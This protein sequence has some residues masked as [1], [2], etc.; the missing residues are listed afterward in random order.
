MNKLSTKKMLTVLISLA[1]VFS[2][3]AVISMAAQ[4]AY[5]TSSPN[6][7]SDPAFFVPGVTTVSYISSGVTFPV[8]SVIYFYISTSTSATGIIGSYVGS[9]SLT[10]GSPTLANVVNISIPSSVSPGSYYL[11][12][13]DS[14]SSTAAGATFPA[15]ASITVSSISPEIALSTSSQV[16]GGTIYISSVASHPFDPASTIEVFLNYP[17]SSIVLI[18]TVTTTSAGLIPSLTSFTVPTNEPQ[19]TYTVVAQE[20]SSLSTAFPNGAPDGI[21]ADASFTLYPSITVSVPDISG[22]T[23]SAFTITGYGFTAGAAIAPYTTTPTAVTVGGVNAVQAGTTVSSSGSFTL[24]IT[25]LAAS[26]TTTGPQTIVITTSPVTPS[27]SFPNIIYVSRPT[28]IPQI[29]VTDLSTST[30]SGYVGDSL[31]II[32]LNMLASSPITVYMA[33][34]TI[35]SGSTDVNGFFSSISGSVPAVPGGTYGVYAEI[36][37]PGASSVSTVSEY[38][39]TQYTVLPLILF[40]QTT[41]TPI[42]GE[43]TPVGASV[44]VSGTGLAPNAEYAITDTG[45]IS[46]GGTG[47]VVYDSIVLGFSTYTGL[48]TSNTIAPDDMGVISDATGS[49]SISY[50]ITYSSLPTG[51]NETISVSGPAMTAQSTYYYAIGAATVTIGAQSYNPASATQMVSV[52]VSGLIPYG[53][54]I[55]TLSG[56]QPVGTYSIVIGTVSSSSSV[57]DV[58]VNG[59]KTAAPTFYTTTGS[60]SLTFPASALSLGLNTVNAVYSNFAIWTTTTDSIVGSSQVL[61]S[62]PSTTVGSVVPVLTSAS[63]GGMLEYNLY[64][65]PASTTVTYSYY[66]VSG[67][68]SSTVSTDAN[69]AANVTFTSPLSPADNYV[70]TFAITFSG[71]TSTVSSTFTLVG[72]LSS[73]P[74]TNASYPL[75]TTTS[76]LYPGQNVT[77]YAYGLSPET[78]YGIYA[79]TS[80]TVPT[81][82]TALAYFTSDSTGSDNSGVTVTLPSTLVSGGSYYLDVVAPTSIVS[83][84]EPALASFTFMAGTYNNI[85]G[86]TYNYTT[87]TLSAFPTELVNFAWTPATLPNAVGGGSTFGPVE[88]TVLLNGTAYTTFP[89][90]FDPT[91]GLI[92]GSFAAPNNNSGAY[93]TVQLEWT[94]IDY[95]SSTGVSA[96]VNTYTMPSKGAPTLA[97]VSGA[98]AL[99]VAISTSDIA[100]IITSS[101]NSAMKVPLSELNASVTAINGLTANITTAFGKM[102]ATLSSIN[103][104]VASISSGQALVVTKLGTIETSLSSINAS[105]MMVSGNVVTL[106][107]TLGKVQTSLSSIGATVSSTASSVS[108]LVGSAAT[109]L[110]DVGPLSGQITGVSN[111]VATIQTSMGKLNVSV[112]QIQT[113]SNQIKTDSGTL[114]IFLIVVIVL[115][116]ITLVVAFLAVSNTNKLAKKLEE[117]K[118]Q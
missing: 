86:P 96:I 1:M 11:L 56:A 32:V 20:T 101:I 80:A 28:G 16:A 37:T 113:S 85:F 76:A 117:Q 95:A 40:M 21:T 47:N 72:T 98:G 26:I 19:G 42:T 112:A 105:L 99:V 110:T 3:L 100:S 61:G 103:A 17:G 9:T 78:Y 2:A 97:L 77:L 102:T 58:Y 46:A 116:L 49:F 114:E 109:I 25:A 55:A 66:T 71:T 50:L 68:Q 91:T 63:P 33:G 87:N 107:T 39:F 53:S 75:T 70:I 67:K 104:T 36:A 62:T 30:N 48:T 13:S 41:T 88:V 23:S 22:S 81:G 94:Q 10:A 69:G 38:A 29:T 43:Y 8:G 79:E 51:A 4:P 6:M 82:A 84:S 35:V 34:T 93:W 44:T 74:Y 31:S 118:K 73:V 111:G 52:S 27:S 59:A 90:V 115:I 92:S 5:A 18:T 7:T 65:F 83:T 12:A 54:A 15:F 14:S 64:D 106:N 108:G 89:A 24:S 60:V 57:T 45:L